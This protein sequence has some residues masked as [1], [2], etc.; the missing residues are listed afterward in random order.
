MLGPL[1]PHI[2][3]D[4]L[5]TEHLLHKQYSKHFAHQRMHVG[6]TQRAQRLLRFSTN[7]AMP[8]SLHSWLSLPDF[9]LLMKGCG[10]Q[11]GIADLVEY[12]LSNRALF[13][14]APTPLDLVT[15]SIGPFLQLLVA[16]P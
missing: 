10:M 16:E 13:N 1:L 12:F 8:S 9:F 6:I 11:C 7:P 2:L 14:L 5:P 15:L 4:W 3:L